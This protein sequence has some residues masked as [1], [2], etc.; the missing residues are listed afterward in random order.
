LQGRVLI[1][2]DVI[3][4]GTAIRESVEIIR[5]AGATPVGVALA[6]DRQERGRDAQGND[7]A[8]SAVQ[9]M[10]R[11]YGIEAVSILSLDGLIA[12]M[13]AGGDVLPAD[14]LAAMEAYRKRYGTA[15]V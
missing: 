3:T 1:V 15:G 2:D 13:R 11:L 7:L 6:L 8:E 12:T 9:E 5:A 14:A 4:A 10:K